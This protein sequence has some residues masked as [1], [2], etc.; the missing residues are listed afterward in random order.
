MPR[1][2]ALKLNFRKPTHISSHEQEQHARGNMAAVSALVPTKLLVVC[3]TTAPTS[4]PSACSE[5]TS[6]KV[7]RSASGLRRPTA[8]TTNHTSISKQRTP[9][10]MSVLAEDRSLKNVKGAMMKPPTTSSTQNENNVSSLSRL[11]ESIIHKAASTTIGAL[12]SKDA[13]ALS[14]S[15]G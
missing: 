1:M 15:P 11:F 13:G 8:M 4:V 7:G 14:T 12:I 2:A 10:R 6:P 9:M 3:P 5:R